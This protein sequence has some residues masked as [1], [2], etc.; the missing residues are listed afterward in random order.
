MNPQTLE[1]RIHGVNNTAPHA[2]LALPAYAIERV[3]GDK[4]GSFWRPNAD[5]VAKLPKDNAAYVPDGLRREAYW[6][7]GIARTSPGAPGG[8]V[9]SVV[10]NVLG[11]IGWALLLPFGLANVAYWSRKL[12]GETEEKKKQ[13]QPCKWWNWGTGA[14]STR[15]F[16]LGLTILL[17]LTVCEVAIDMFA[18]QCGANGRCARLPSILRVLDDPQ[19]SI[20]V[21][22][23]SVAPVLMLVGLLV[24]TSLSRSRYEVHSAN[25]AGT[26]RRGIVLSKR[27]MWA[28]N[29][30]LRR[31]TRLHLAT[32]FAVVTLTTSADVRHEHGAFAVVAIAAIILVLVAAFRVCLT[33]SD[34]PDVPGDARNG[35]WSWGLVA[36]AAILFVVQGFLL[37]NIDVDFTHPL[38]STTWLP[39]GVIATLLCIVLSALSWRS[40]HDDDATQHDGA[41]DAGESGG[42]RLLHRLGNRY[43]DSSARYRKNSARSVSRDDSPRLCYRSRSCSDCGSRTSTPRCGGSRPWAA[44]G[45]W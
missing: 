44:S 5:Y 27:E 2:M 10:V 38:W 21:L 23:A 41:N 37:Y 29:P 45:S 25:H 30:R 9:S 42:T 43:H 40:V 24:L 35:A 3:R 22:R 16:A 12:P 36:A 28:G 18:I 11:R 8:G 4:V 6:W 7:G 33:A 17:V 39:P 1:L 15:L 31:L 19:S 34:S 32:G 13:R 14:A 26:A 20:R